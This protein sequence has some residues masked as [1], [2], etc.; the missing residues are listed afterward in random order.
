MPSRDSWERKGETTQLDKAEGAEPYEL[1]RLVSGSVKD[2]MPR[3]D[4]LITSFEMASES[5]EKMAYRLVWATWAL[6]LATVGLI[7]TTLLIG[8]GGKG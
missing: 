3:L 4:R 1:A 7:V 6:V 2:F 5:S 8:L